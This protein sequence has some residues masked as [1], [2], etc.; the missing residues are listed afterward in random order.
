MDRAT[1]EAN[2]KQLPKPLV[3]SLA[4]DHK[5]VF[6]LRDS[7]IDMV[8]DVLA[9]SKPQRILEIGT[10]LGHSACLFLSL[11][12]AT[13]ISIDI[14]T[15]WVEWE[16]GYEDWEVPKAE[17][18]GGQ[19]DVVETLQRLF[20]NRFLFIKA[21]STRSTGIISIA[22]NT[23]YDLAFIDGNHDLDYVER[24][25]ETALVLG[26]PYILLDDCTSPSESTWVAAKKY[27]LVLVKRYESIHN[28]ADIGCC[29]FRHPQ[30]PL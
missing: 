28:M 1:L 14:G 22:L 30:I 9:R 21:D 2:L 24:D 4:F 8:T 25:I 12:E 23:P 29:L 16:Y 19:K 10:H 6:R 11:S 13:V 17:G 5:D 7:C 3:G 18:G 27:N 20:P 15:H 26:I